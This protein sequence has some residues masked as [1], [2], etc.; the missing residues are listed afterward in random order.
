ME[1]SGLREALNE[2]ERLDMPVVIVGASIDEQGNF[3]YPY[4]PI[5]PETVSPNF[6]SAPG[7]FAIMDHG[8]G[9]W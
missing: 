7:G 9:D 2:F 4:Y 3:T 8:P 1:Y 6:L 5:D